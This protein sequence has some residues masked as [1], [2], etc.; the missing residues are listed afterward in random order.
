MNPLH[1]LSRF[2]IE[3]LNLQYDMAIGLSVM[4]SGILLFAGCVVLAVSIVAIYARIRGQDIDGN[5]LA[6]DGVWYVK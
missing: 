4:I 3:T 1:T 6:K 5:Q 2:F